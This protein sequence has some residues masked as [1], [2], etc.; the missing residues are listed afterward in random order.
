M[1]LSPATTI[2]VLEYL[3]AGLSPFYLLSGA[4]FF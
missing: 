4:Y 2:S 1:Q 3:I